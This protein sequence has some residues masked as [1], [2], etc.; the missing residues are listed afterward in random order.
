MKSLILT[1]A[2]GL[3]LAGCSSSKSE[4]APAAMAPSSA[5]TGGTNMNMASPGKNMPMM[6]GCPEKDASHTVMADTPVYSGPP[7]QGMPPMA[8]LKSG[9]KVLVMTPGSEYAKCQVADG[10]TVY[11]KTAMLRPY[12]G[13][14]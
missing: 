5:T 7:G 11:V 2:A 13:T 14:N 12:S 10:K 3:S 9:T 8:I 1:L 6:M 4:P